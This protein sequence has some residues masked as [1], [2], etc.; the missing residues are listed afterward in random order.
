MADIKGLRRN[1]NV[2][3]L[4]FSELQPNPVDQF[5][6]WFDA[7]RSFDL[8]DWFEAN[9]MTLSTRSAKSVSSRIVLLKEY[10]NRGFVFFSNY[11]SQKADELMQFPDAALNFFWPMQERQVR[12][13]GTV[14]RISADESDAYFSS[15][16]KGSQYGAVISN[17]ST[18]IGADEDLE[19]TLTRMVDDDVDVKRPADWGGYRLCPTEVEFWQGRP[20]RLHDR[21]RYRREGDAWKIERLAP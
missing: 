2:G 20:S 12:L 1:Y 11:G 19:A 15:R 6:Q 13:A 16:P 21:F 3:R 17:Q 14:E 4:V 10:D 5:S 7:L 18:V 9:A 8:P